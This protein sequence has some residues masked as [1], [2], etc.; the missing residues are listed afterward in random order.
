MRNVSI[1]RRYAR[2]LLEVASERGSVDRVTDQLT[3][4]ARAVQQNPD[5][6]DVLANPAF[7]RAQ[8]MAVMDGLVRVAGDVDPSVVNLLRLLVDRSRFAYLSDIARVYRDLADAMAGR[9]RGKVTSARPLDG[10]VLSRLEQSLER[11]LQRDVVLDAQVN[12]KLIGGVAAQVGSV[13]Y[14][15][16]LRTQLEELRRTLRT[17]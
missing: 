7:T 11:L 9:V 8:R 2:A 5:V 3:G 10:Q 1:A 4:F 6:A 16:S 14:D 13:L 17:R 15:G 12:P